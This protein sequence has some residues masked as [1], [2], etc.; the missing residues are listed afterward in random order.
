MQRIEEGGADLVE[1]FTNA[2]GADTSCV[3]KRSNVSTCEKVRFRSAVKIPITE[4]STKGEQPGLA[5]CVLEK[6]TDMC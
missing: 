5:V 3:F 4:V 2:K 1:R 6:D